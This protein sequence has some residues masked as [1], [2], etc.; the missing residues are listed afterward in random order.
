MLPFSCESC[1][2][3]KKCCVYFTNVVF[4][5]SFNRTALFRLCEWVSFPSFTPSNPFIRSL[6]PA[7][8]HSW[9]T[10]HLLNCFFISTKWKQRHICTR[11]IPQSFFFFLWYA[12]GRVDL[13]IINII[14]AW[15]RG[16]SLET[17]LWA[18]PR[19][20]G[21]ELRVLWP[22]SKSK[23]GNPPHIGLYAMGGV[24]RRFCSELSE[25]TWKILVNSLVQTV[26]LGLEQLFR[27]QRIQ[28]RLSEEKK[29][30]DFY[31]ETGHRLGECWKNKYDFDVMNLSSGFHGNKCFGFTSCLG[32]QL[33][34]NLWFDLLWWNSSGTSAYEFILKVKFCIAKWILP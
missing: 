28:W 1:F 9:W 14:P 8:K 6:L 12:N 22:R 24:S 4:S 10:N 21:T 2:I 16:T 26:K 34:Y 18:D 32:C 17:A 7:C 27:V 11:R 3:S 19:L 15:E 31:P 23:Q 33:S 25:V 30:S 5:F 20:S 29:P 13:V